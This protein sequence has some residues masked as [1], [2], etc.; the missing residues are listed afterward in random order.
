MG[1]KRMPSYI[2]EGTYQ[3]WQWA[4]GPQRAVCR[5]CK[6]FTRVDMSKVGHRDV[7]RSPFRC[8][9]CGR[10]AGYVCND[11]DLTG[12]EEV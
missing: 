9:K 3:L 8:S 2:T 7:K 12:Y 1:Q 4:F 10:E 6:R 5:D 11:E